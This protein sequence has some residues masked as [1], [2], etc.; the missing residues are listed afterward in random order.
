MCALLLRT[1]Q[2][3]CQVPGHPSLLGKAR[4]RGKEEAKGWARGKARDW[5]RG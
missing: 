4:A 5:A 2:A 1:P 3:Q